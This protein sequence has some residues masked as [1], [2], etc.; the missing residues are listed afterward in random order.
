MDRPQDRIEQDRLEVERL[1]LDSR[2]TEL[3]RVRPWIDEIA[4]RVGLPEEKRFAVQLCIEETVANVILH[5]YRSEPGHPVAI[6]S[7]I[8]DG[9]LSFTV[10]DQAPPFSPVEFD[11]NSSNGNAETLSLESMT[12]GGNGIRL[13]KHFSGSLRYE[14]TSNGNRLTIVF[15]GPFGNSGL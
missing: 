10:D 12:P 3:I 15:P 2:L 14:R 7:L 8:A 6:T 9:S 13:L 5:G 4:D 1:E 11:L